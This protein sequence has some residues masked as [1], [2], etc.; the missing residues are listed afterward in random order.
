M[1][2]AS[3]RKSPVGNCEDSF[4]GDSRL[5]ILPKGYDWLEGQGVEGGGELAEGYHQRVHNLQGKQ[6]NPKLAEGHHQGVHNLQ[7]NQANPKI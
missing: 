7:G 2:A 1:C 4:G 3:T 5:L 6:A